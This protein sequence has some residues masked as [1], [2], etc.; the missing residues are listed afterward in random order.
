MPGNPFASNPN[1]NAQR[2]IAYGLRNQ[3]RFAFRPGTNELWAGDVG[4]NTWEEINRIP[5]ATDNVAENFGW[6]CY[7]GAARQSGY[8]GANL[9]L[10]ETLYGTGQTAP[11]YTYNHSASVAT[12]DGCPTGGS[13]VSGIAFETTS[14]YPAAYDGALFFSDSSR[15]CIWAMRRGANGLPEP[16]EHRAVRDRR[17]RPGAGADRPRRRPVLR[18]AR[19]RPAAAGELPGGR[20]SRR[21]R[22]PPRPRRPVPRR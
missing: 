8:D 4:W 7:E 19:R 20:T 13:S 18:R 1:V 10:C 17:E 12:G 2:I 22:S 16:G 11:Y 14:N 15:G 9:T 6:P 3:F 21:P 5:N